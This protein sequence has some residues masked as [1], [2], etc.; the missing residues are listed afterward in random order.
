MKHKKLPPL[1]SKNKLALEKQDENL[2]LT[3]LEGAVIANN[4]PTSKVQVDCPN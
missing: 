4:S 2:K 3:E 1:S